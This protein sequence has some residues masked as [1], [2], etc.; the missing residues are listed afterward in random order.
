ML[1]FF[2]KLSVNARVEKALKTRTRKFVPWEKIEKIALIISKDAGINKSAIDK[3]IEDSKKYIEVFYIELRSKEASFG[4][5][6]CFSKKDSSLLKLPTKRVEDSV[7]GRHY[8]VVINACEGKNL[9]SA[10]LFSTLDGTLKCASS[11]RFKDA[12]LI[13]R[14]TDQSNLLS[15]LSDTVHY[16]KMIRV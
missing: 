3:F 5:W 14:R 10:A 11:A 1:S 6:H 15:F 12:D 13:I 9:F 4:D 2:A 8:D 16:L 7:K